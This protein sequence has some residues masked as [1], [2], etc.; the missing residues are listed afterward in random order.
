MFWNW[1]WH[2]SYLSQVQRAL[3]YTIFQSSYWFTC[4]YHGICRTNTIFH[5]HQSDT[6]LHRNSDYI[7]IYIVV[8][9]RILCQQISQRRMG[10]DTT[11]ITKIVVAHTTTTISIES[12]LYKHDPYDISYIPLS[13]HSKKF[14]FP[15]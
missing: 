7:P 10:T 14:S 13:F 4:R 5:P 15:R 11:S 6:S 3:V 8:F 1:C 2:C 9:R 12:I